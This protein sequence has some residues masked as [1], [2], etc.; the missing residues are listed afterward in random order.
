ML[1][2]SRKRESVKTGVPGLPGDWQEDAALRRKLS[3]LPWEPIPRSWVRRRLRR[4]RVLVERTFK[5]TRF[6][7]AWLQLRP[8]EDYNWNPPRWTRYGMRFR[9]FVGT[10]LGRIEPGASIY[11][12]PKYDAEGHRDW[13]AHQPEEFILREYGWRKWSYIQLV[14]ADVW[15]EQYDFS[16]I[17]TCE[18]WRNWHIHVDETST[19]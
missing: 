16:Y 10:L 3:I 1:H 4:A 12:H 6:Y 8:T 9:A 18:G 11:R 2:L 17:S 14:A 5:D 13:F 19:C 15:G 7:L